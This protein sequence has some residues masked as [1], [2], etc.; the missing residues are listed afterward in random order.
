MFYDYNCTAC[1]K[2]VEVE[3]GMKDP[4]PDK[5][6]ECGAVGS[7]ERNWG[8]NKPIATIY[9]CKDMYDTSVRGISVR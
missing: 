9:N 4:T 7:L 5:C 8:N 3:K 2:T 6:P 1:K